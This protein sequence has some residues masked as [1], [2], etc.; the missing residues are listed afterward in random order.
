MELAATYVVNNSRLLYT[1]VKMTVLL[2]EATFMRSRMF[3]S[4]E[5]HVVTQHEGHLP[6]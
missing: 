6:I 4:R 1:I 3:E 2:H 5:V